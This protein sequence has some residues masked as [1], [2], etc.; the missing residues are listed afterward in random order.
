MRLI[1]IPRSHNPSRRSRAIGDWKLDPEQLSFSSQP[2]S[3]ARAASDVRCGHRGGV[4]LAG[5]SRRRLA[6]RSI[7]L[8]VLFGIVVFFAAVMGSGVILAR[9][10]RRGRIRCCSILAIAAEREM[11]LAPAVVAFADQ[12]RGG[13]HRRIMHLA[14]EL[15]GGAMLPEALERVPRTSSRAT[16]VLL[17]WVGQAAGML[18]KALR[19]AAASRLV[20]PADLDGD[21]RAHFLHPH[22]PPGHA[23]DHRPLSCIIIMPK[24]EAI[25]KDFATTACPA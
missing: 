16:R 10:G 20:L 24:F 19:V 23:D 9:G 14:A 5:D 13:S 18:P 15:N 1:E 4:A 2:G 22:A 6:R 7:F 25:F 21:R 3:L 12:Y 11:P 8:L 17:A